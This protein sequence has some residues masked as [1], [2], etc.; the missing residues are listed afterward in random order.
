MNSPFS[1]YQT[2]LLCYISKPANFGNEISTAGGEFSIPILLLLVLMNRFSSE[3]QLSICA[4]AFLVLGHLAGCGPGAAAAKR[5]A[6]V[7]VVV[8]IHCIEM[9]TVD[10]AEFI[11]RTDAYKTV[12]V[13]ARV[14]GFIKQVLF[15]DGAEV[16]KDQVLFKIE[17]EQYQAVLAQADSRIALLDAQLE[18][19]NTKLAR[20]K[21]LIDANAISREEYDENI[22][23]VKEANAS[24][25]AARADREIALLD[26][27]YTDVKAEMDGRID[28]ALITEGNVVSGGLFNGTLLTRIVENNP[29]YVFFDVD[30]RSLLNYQR[31]LAVRDPSNQEPKIVDNA[32]PCY[33][34]LQ[35]ES[36]FN[37]K[38]T[39]N[40]IENRADAAT[41]T[42]RVRAQFENHDNVLTGGLFVRIRIPKQLQP[43]K[44]IVVPE[45]AIITDQTAKSVL[46]VGTDRKVEK[47]SIS[48][49]EQKGQLRVVADG[50]KPGEMIVL[51][52]IQ[53]VRVNE[54]VEL[55]AG[56]ETAEAAFYDKAK[57]SQ[58][59]LDSAQVSTELPA[60]SELPAAGSTSTTGTPDAPASA[61]PPTSSKN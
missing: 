14:S 41:G 16:K 39:L 34:Q 24:I 36:T 35:D 27:N 3:F 33:I 29:M 30:E 17:S 19:A 6:P 18:L 1:V 47:R 10:F 44:A 25:A 5:E 45:Q 21:K 61:A 37:R 13:R 11:G 51:D 40:F 22:A 26:V 60:T 32:Y 57:A 56:W 2:E 46:V 53:K 58:P 50:L 12:E 20:A 43:Y 42:I 8:P 48:I 49:G 38:G 31:L 4:S 55:K 59:Q 9:E 7:P 15:T 52:G 28:R 23:A 54:A